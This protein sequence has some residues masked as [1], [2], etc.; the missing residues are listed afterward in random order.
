MNGLSITAINLTDRTEIYWSLRSKFLR[1]AVARISGRAERKQKLKTKTSKTPVDAISL[2]DFAA[3][4]VLQP[5]WTSSQVFSTWTTAPAFVRLYHRQEKPR[6]QFTAYCLLVL[7]TLFFSAKRGVL[8]LGCLSL[9]GGFRFVRQRRQ[10]YLDSMTHGL[11][12]NG[13]KTINN[14]EGFYGFW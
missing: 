12:T 13:R 9:Q 11:K 2:S 10:V 7:V 1:L 5:L 14:R 4:Q 8:L 6:K 3:L